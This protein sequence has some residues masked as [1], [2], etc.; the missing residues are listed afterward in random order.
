MAFARLMSYNLAVARNVHEKEEETSSSPLY[1][2]RKP[3]FLK[4]VE[5]N[6]I[7]LMKL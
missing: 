4:H 2:L 1:N 5:I 7:L 3:W 6:E